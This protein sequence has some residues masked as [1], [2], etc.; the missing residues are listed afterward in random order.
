MKQKAL[1]FG[2]T[3]FA[4]VAYVYLRDDSDY[5]VVGFVVNEQYIAEPT[6]L[7]L[8]VIPF[9]TVVDS[10]PPVHHA[11]FLGIGFSKVNAARRSVYDSV[12]QLG[13]ALPTYIHSTVHRWPETTFG[14][15]C[16]VFENN[17][18]QPYVTIGNNCVLWSGNH[19]GHHSKV[20]NN[21]FIASHVVISGKCTI[22]DN[23]FVGVN[24]TF[25]DGI[26]V[27][28]DCVIG[29]GA[30]LL[31]DAPDAS[32]YKS[33]ATEASERKSSDLRNF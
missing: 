10:H 13:Y 11:V 5:E 6:L 9:E 7:G 30:V 17:V 33:T 27:G 1:I 12:K 19:V 2:T 26:T 14:E 22:G 31:K 16:F 32:V 4:Q 8:P 21:V 20:G 29:A 15:A 3:D 18:V 25:R 24:A 23:S 28:R